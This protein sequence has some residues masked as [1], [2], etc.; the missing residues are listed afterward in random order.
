MRHDS[1]YV[2]QLGRPGG[3][4]VGRLIPI[5]D[6]EPNPGQPRQEIGDLTELAAS[7]RENGILEPLLV[8][9][10]DGRFQII[11]GE[12]RY[13]AAVEVGLAE[14]PC[15]VREATDAE[16]MELALVENLQ[17][18]DLSAFEEADG[19]KALSTTYGYTHEKM[20]QKV[21]KSRTAITE[22]MAIA[23]LPENV[24]EQCRLADIHSKSLL[25]QVVR[26]S[27]PK[28]ML[29]FVERMKRD[30]AATRQA[31]RRILKEAKRPGRGRP[32]NYA[33]HFEPA[34]KAFALTIQFRRPQVER[35]ELI[36]ALQSALDAV[37]AK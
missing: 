22:T 13:R 36:A 32:R 8:R 17:R 4:P 20:A 21:G 34:G 18:K 37:R 3:A 1:H 12:R 15:I 25:L 2:D 26:H 10:V 30:G 28:K 29:E 35:D 14:L 33:Y 5:E 11:A 31:G 9:P 24:R 6:V 7:M 19:L 27:E 23:A 16:V